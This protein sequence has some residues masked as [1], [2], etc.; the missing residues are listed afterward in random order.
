VATLVDNPHVSEDDARRIL[1]A[2]AAEL[3]GFD[4]D[5]LQPHIDAHGFDL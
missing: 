4:L 2:N 1:Y 5:A 3:Y